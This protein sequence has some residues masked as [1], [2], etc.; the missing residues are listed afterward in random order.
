MFPFWFIY[1]ENPIH[2]IKLNESLWCIAILLVLLSISYIIGKAI[3]EKEGFH[4]RYMAEAFNFQEDWPK[5]DGLVKHPEVDGVYVINA[6]EL[7]EIIFIGDSHTKQYQPRIVEQAMS[8]R[9]NVGL[10]TKMAA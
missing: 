4:D 1:N 10:I 6:N 9:L 8:R 2:R 5:M 3:R 7:P